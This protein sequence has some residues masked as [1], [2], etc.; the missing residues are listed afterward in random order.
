MRTSQAAESLGLTAQQLMHI[1]KNHA[2]DVPKDGDR[3]AWT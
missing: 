2:I 3:Y 1:R